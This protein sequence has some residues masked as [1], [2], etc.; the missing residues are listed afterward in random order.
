MHH[1]GMPWQFG[2]KGIAKSA[3]ANRSTPHI[4]DANSFIPEYKERFLC[5][6]RGAK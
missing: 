3:R 2:Y 1:I 4:G 5:D 6:V